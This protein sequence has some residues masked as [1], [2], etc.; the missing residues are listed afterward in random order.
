MKG[1]LSVLGQK[2]A[3]ECEIRGMATLGRSAKNEI[4][5]NDP[6]VSHKHAMIFWDESRGYVIRD[7]GSSNGTF[8]NGQKIEQ[9]QILR[10]GDKI[11]LGMTRCRFFCDM[12]VKMEDTRKDDLTTTQI[13]KILPS[14]PEKFLPSGEIDDISVLRTDYEKLRVTYELQ[15]D[16]GFERNIDRIMDKILKRT[17]EFLNYDRGVIL[18]AVENGQLKPIAFNTPGKSESPIISSTLIK[19]IQKEKKSILSTD[20]LMDERLQDVDSIIFQNVRSTLCV[21]I[22]YQQELLGIII[23]DSLKTTKIY[24]EKDLEL[25]VS[26]ANRSAEFIIN[27]R[28]ARKIEQDAATRERFQR[29]LSPALA[30]MVVS[31]QLKVKKGGQSTIATVLFIDIRG[32]TSMSESMEAAEVLEM[33]NAFF[34]V[35]VEVVFQYEGTVDKFIGDCMMVIWGTPVYHEDHAI[36]A[37]RAALGMKKSLKQFNHHRLL[38]GETPVSVGIGINTGSLVA[39]YMGSSRTMSYSVIGDTVNIASRL[40]SVALPDQIII[41]DSTFHYVCHLVNAV[42]LDSIMAKGKQKPIKAFNVIG[43]KQTVLPA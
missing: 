26:I 40:C 41:S 24:T 30:E 38:C 9:E 16:I 3:R 4:R 39:G 33:L 25:L 15:R 31:G 12:P 1:V 10:K 14:S 17:V 32:F 42:R 34:E 29:L 35:L 6:A 2:N 27:S 37:V 11:T 22:L 8:V 23:V 43:K 13:Q 18:I 21:P 19:Y 7:L 5:L 28:M 36:R 20:T